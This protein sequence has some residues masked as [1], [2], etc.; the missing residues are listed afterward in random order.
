V[1]CSAVQ[2]VGITQVFQTVAGLS[3]QLTLGNKKTLINQGK[4]N[5]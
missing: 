1:E 5:R 4:N 3:L 2:K